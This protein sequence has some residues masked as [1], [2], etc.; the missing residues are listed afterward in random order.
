MENMP[1]IATRFGS[2][3]G[4]ETVAQRGADRGSACTLH[5]EDDFTET[6]DLASRVLIHD[7]RTVPVK[8]VVAGRYAVTACDDSRL[9][10]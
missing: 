6:G 1:H 8:K 9:C 4:A 3:T 10:V 7:R 5:A 2:E